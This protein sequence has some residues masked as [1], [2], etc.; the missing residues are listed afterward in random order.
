MKTI[1]FLLCIGLLMANM[2]ISN[3][4]TVT[5]LLSNGSQAAKFDIVFMGDGFTAAQQAEYNTLVN[6][7]FNAIWTYNNGPL[8]DVLAELQDAVNVYRVNMNSVNSGVSKFTCGGD[9]GCP[10]QTASN[11]NTAYA[12][13]YSGCW[14]CCWM[15]KG[16]DTDTRINNALATVGLSGA[17]Y[18]VMIL[19]EPGFGGCSYGRVLSITKSTSNNVLMHELGHSVGDLADE[20]SRPGCFDGPEPAR[21]NVSIVANTPKWNM[22]AHTTTTTGNPIEYNVSQT[23][24]EFLG[25]QYRETCIHRPASNS[26][27]RGNTNLFNPPCYDN[28]WVRQKPRSAYNFNKVYSGNFKGTAAADVLL[29]FGNHIAAYEVGAPDG[30]TGAGT[31]SRVKS[32]YITTKVFTGSGGTW[33]ISAADQFYTGDFSGDGK[34]DLVVFWPNGTNSRLGMMTA[35]TT[36]FTCTRIFTTS[37]AGWQMQTNDQYYLADFNGDGRKDIYVFNTQ[38]WTMGYMGMLSSTGSNLSYVKR[39][40]QYLPG[41]FMSNTDK[42]YVA[43]IN[44]DNK[45]EFILFNTASKVTRL[46]KTNAAGTEVSISAEYFASLPGWTSA[47]KDQYLVADFNGDN[48]DD[49]YIFNG[50]DWGPEYLVMLRSNGTG[51]DYVIRYDNTLP[52]WDMNDNDSYYVGDFN[53][54]GKEELLMYNTANWD[55]EYLG[56]TVSTGTG[57]TASWQKDW[58]GSWNLGGVDKLQV[59]NAR[60][61]SDALFIS[62]Q[63]WF[64][65]L[66][67]S[68]SGM[69][70]QA[71][72]K[73][74]IHTFKH[75]DWGWY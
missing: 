22:F 63:D 27:M 24:N 39:Y 54:D 3:A 21:R 73:D 41:H 65:Y 15:S 34:D 6:N 11:L 60:T 48:K 50:L 23:T 33:N 16:A 64:G 5:T 38:N 74:Y 57:L 42:Y 12:F 67:P 53:G 75:H 68:G 58:I 44:G 72:Y 37:L 69:H 51:Y 52:G 20:Y 40:D 9:P 30:F 32:S 13:R 55:S 62:N 29:H 35:T 8:D 19:N 36:G 47:P 1:K 66:I 28:F 18:V 26:A 71:I 31:H 17:D 4:Q 59:G 56:R 61:G 10:A 2:F 45:E 46:F 7:Y 70:Q 14:D 49:L 43:D 25:G